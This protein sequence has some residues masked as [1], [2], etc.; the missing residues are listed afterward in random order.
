MSI[1]S[2]LAAGASGLLANSSALASIS[3]NIA[4]VNTIGYKRVDTVFTP[5]YKIQGGGE[6]RYASAGVQ[7]RTRLDV[8]SEGL[9]NPAASETDLA[10]DGNGFFLVRPNPT[11]VTGADPVLFTRSGGFETDDSGYLRNDAGQYLYGWPVAADGSVVQNPS[12][13]DLLE[14]I[15][16]SN[17]GGAAEATSAI[18]INANLQASEDVSPAEA[19][20]DPT[21]PLNNMAS[22]AVTPDFQ[23]TIQIY[24][25]QGG[26][27]SVT[28]SLLK[29]STA[30]Q[31]HA[32]LHIEPASDVTTGAGLN[33]GQI[34]TGVLAFNTN[35]QIDSAN[36][37]LPNSLSFL[38]SDYTGALGA[39]EFQWAAAT[40]IGSQAVS[41]DLGSAGNPG[42]IT[43]YDSPSVLNSTVVNGAVFGDFA[44]V[45]VS[46]DGFVSARF[47]NGVV[48][49][50]YQIPIAT[51][52]NPNGLASV[53]GGSYQITDESGAF[54]LNPPGIGSS[55][56]ISSKTLENSNVDIA[57][58]FSN[59][60]ITQRAYSASSRIIT[61]ADEMLAEAIQMKR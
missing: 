2:A 49:Q 11:N 7:A 43:Q 56:K 35:G 10:I 58:E 37:T 55:G 24:D 26:V 4:N 54:T 20:Y 42:G 33:N 50:V 57:T 18:R 51:V 21:D 3:D 31:W 22:G 9:L 29:S 61:T 40:G 36:T 23:R 13:V 8:S 15:N 44:G 52:V 34:A 47:T 14:A 48:R 27:R 1:N 25:S 46:P 17:I 39:N 38:G 28:L 45:E 30:N 12:N 53:G 19:A 41:L 5:N 60:I 32:E 16:L 59:L 6:S